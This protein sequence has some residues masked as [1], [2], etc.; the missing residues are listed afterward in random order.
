M[1]SRRTWLCG[2]AVRSGVGIC[3]EPTSIDV[4]DELVVPEL[5]S[6]PGMAG[7]SLW[8]AA[9][10]LAGMRMD[11]VVDRLVRQ[12]YSRWADTPTGLSEP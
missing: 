6:I 1:M 8:P 7:T 11:V 9:V 12:A 10:E 4:G 3:I 2:F 5:N